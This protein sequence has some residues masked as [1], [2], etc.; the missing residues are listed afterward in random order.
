MARTGD[1][2]VPH[3]PRWAQAVNVSARHL[4]LPAHGLTVGARQPGHHPQPPTL[5]PQPQD[6][7]DLDHRNLR[8]SSCRQHSGRATGNPQPRRGWCHNWQ[9]PRP[10]GGNDCKRRMDFEA[11]DR[12]A[13]ALASESGPGDGDH[14]QGGGRRD[15]SPMPERAAMFAVKLRRAGGQPASPCFRPRTGRRSLLPACAARSPA[16]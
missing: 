15:D 11:G 12:A 8:G 13:E 7:P 4:H 14:V 2:H 9:H 5:Q 10:G 6:L 3:V 16:P 1:G